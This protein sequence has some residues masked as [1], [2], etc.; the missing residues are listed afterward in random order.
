MV[1]SL[2]NSQINYKESNRLNESDKKHQSALYVIDLF[3]SPFVIALGQRQDEH[4]AHN[5]YFYAIYLISPKKKIKAKIGVFEIE[6][7]ILNT[8]MDD[9]G[10]VNIEKLDEPLLFSYIT[11]EYLEKYGSHG[12]EEKEKEVETEEVPKTDDIFVAAISKGKEKDKEK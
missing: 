5:I 11:P 3:N 12:F 8:I 6:S 9:D 4:K 10:D 2:K 1:K 7:H